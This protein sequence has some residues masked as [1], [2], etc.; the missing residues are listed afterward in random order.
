MTA[1]AAGLR[2]SVH[3]RVATVT[4]ARPERLNALSRPLIAEL[5]EVVERLAASD[6][7][8]VLVLEGEGRLF[9]AGADIDEIQADALA[10]SNDDEAV[11]ADARRGARLCAALEDPAIVAIA[12]VQ[13]HAIGGAAALIASCDLRVLAGDAKLVVPELAMG[14][15]LAWGGIERLARDLGPAVLRDLLLTG[16]PLTADEALARGFATAVVERDAL[17]DHAHAQ[18]TLIASRPG[19]GTTAALRRVLAVADRRD[20]AGMDDDAVTLARAAAQDEAVAATEAYMAS[21]AKRAPETAPT[22]GGTDDHS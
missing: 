6:D 13:G 5:T 4:L 1:S 14:L 21:L 20:A 11:I 7:V 10:G 15:P 12:A 22:E 3:D 17:H 19:F 16:R 2:V 8:R 18:A 9:S